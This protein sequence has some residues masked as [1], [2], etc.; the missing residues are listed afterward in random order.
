MCGCY[1]KGKIKIAI[2]SSLA[3][4]LI[5]A[6]VM[7]CVF[8]A[9]RALRN[10]VASQGVLSVKLISNHDDRVE[11][12]LD[13]QQLQDFWKQVDKSKY[14]PKYDKIKGVQYKIKKY[15]SDGTV[16]ESKD[17]ILKIDIFEEYRDM[18]RK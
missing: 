17:M 2:S 15:S 16:Q 14:S 11:V 13:G 6:I 18:F 8:F 7:I 1:M 4:L 12:Q 10:D 5:V 3:I 9:P